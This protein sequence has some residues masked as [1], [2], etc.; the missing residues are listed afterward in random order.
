MAFGQ[1]ISRPPVAK[2]KN[3]YFYFIFL[4]FFIFFALATGGLD[5]RGPKAIRERMVLRTAVALNGEK[6]KK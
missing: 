2:A 1:R 3:K 5:M 6:L 4:F